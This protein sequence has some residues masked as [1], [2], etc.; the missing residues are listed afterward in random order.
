MKQRNLDSLKLLVIAFLSI[1]AFSNCD[2]ESYSKYEKPLVMK[3]GLLYSDS[4]S[5]KPY[6][7]KHSSKV[8]NKIIEY[9]VVDGVKEGKFTLYYENGMIE[10]TG[11]IKQNLNDGLWKYFSSDGRLQQTGRYKSD[12]PDGLWEWFYGNGKT[13]E[14]GAFLNGQRNGEWKTYDTSGTL[15]IKRVFENDIL[16]DSTYFE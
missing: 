7:G 15:R 1:L 5:S 9:E 11:N 16:V 12:K 4:L 3:D 10:M 13:F 2:N 8:M 6:S 14:E